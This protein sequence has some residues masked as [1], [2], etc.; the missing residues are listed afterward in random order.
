MAGVV[1]GGVK[2]GLTGLR[3][4]QGLAALPPT[5]YSLRRSRRCSLAYSSSSDTPNNNSMMPQK[6]SRDDSRPGKIAIGNNI[7]V[8]DRADGVDREIDQLRKTQATLPPP[9]SFQTRKRKPSA[10][11]W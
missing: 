6:T 3:A 11:R 8:A 7:A 2:R 5:F 1:T 9:F 4:T 10:R